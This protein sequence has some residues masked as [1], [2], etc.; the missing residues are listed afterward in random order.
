[1]HVFT[2]KRKQSGTWLKSCVLGI[3]PRIG[4]WGLPKMTLAETKHVVSTSGE[5]TY[6]QVK[7]DILSELPG[8]LG[9]CS[10]GH[11]AG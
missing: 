8:L 1:M 5:Q 9:G 3:A 6:A 4:G 10:L 11:A 2:F 7:I